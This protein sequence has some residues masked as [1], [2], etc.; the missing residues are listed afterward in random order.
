[1][2]SPTSALTSAAGRCFAAYLL[3]WGMAVAYLGATGGDWSFPLVAL[4]I[5]GLGGSLLTMALTR[6]VK[7]PPV[8]VA[9]PWPELVAV[10]V[11][12]LLYAFVFLGP[13]MS[14]AKGALPPGREHDLLVAAVKLVGHV[15]LPLLLLKALGSR[16]APIFS[17]GLPA[18]LFWRVALVLGGLLIGLLAVVSPSLK[19]LAAVGPDAVTLAWAIP[20]NFLFIAMVAGLNEEFLFRGVLQTRLA[21]VLGTAL[22][23]APIAAV[24]F[25]LAH[26]PGLYLRGG[27]GIDGWSTDPWAVAAFTIATLSPLGVMLGVIYWRTRSLWLVVILHGAIDFLPSLPE[28]I[29]TWR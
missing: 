14:W 24:L 23:A 25:G 18:R 17:G 5:F 26:W 6:G 12:L 19:N 7:L 27:P 15:V 8:P 2:T 11:Y 22:G 21:A 28:F 10:L 9:R 29:T 3:L 4:V 13:V 1:M 16:I 20:A